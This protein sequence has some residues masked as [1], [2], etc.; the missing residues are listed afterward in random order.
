METVVGG[1]GRHFHKYFRYCST[2]IKY[3]HLSCH[4]WN[5]LLQQGTLGKSG[6]EWFLAKILPEGQGSFPYLSLGDAPGQGMFHNY[7][8]VLG[9][10]QGMFHAYTYILVGERN[11]KYLLSAGKWDR[12]CSILGSRTSDRECPI[13]GYWEVGAGVFHAWL[14]GGG[15]RD[16]L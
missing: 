9:L 3:F 10:E 12:E 8:C 5:V 2:F 1:G 11:V 4:L 7:T 15:E 14:L 13:P 16:V 6:R